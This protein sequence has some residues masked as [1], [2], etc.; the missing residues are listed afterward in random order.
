M[1]YLIHYSIP[2]EITSYVMSA[3]DE[4]TLATFI[5]MLV[6]EWAYNIEV[7]LLKK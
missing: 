1:K 5:N 4:H 7:E 2:Y 3:K 6:N